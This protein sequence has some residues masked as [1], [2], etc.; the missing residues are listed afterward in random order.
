MAKSGELPTPLDFVAVTDH[1]ESF[2]DLRLC[3]TPG[4]PVFDEPICQGMRGGDPQTMGRVIG[5]WIVDGAK[6]N[7]AS[8]GEDDVRSV[9][10]RRAG[11]GS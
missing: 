1:A 8:C 6:R 3:V 10:K 4:S 5:G 9:S 2:G 11:P 7:P